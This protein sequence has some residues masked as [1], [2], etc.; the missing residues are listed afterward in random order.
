MLTLAQQFRN[1]KPTF[2]AYLSAAAILQT[3]TQNTRNKAHS[4]TA[5]QRDG[6]LAWGAPQKIC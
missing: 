6:P 4:S 3:L 1:I 2:I 5:L